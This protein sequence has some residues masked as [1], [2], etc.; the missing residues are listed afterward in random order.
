MS[1]RHG[2]DGTNAVSDTTEDRDLV[3]MI[4]EARDPADIDRIA[5][6]ARHRERSRR[7]AA[8]GSPAERPRRRGLRLGRA[9]SF[10][11]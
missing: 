2:L 7:R 5:A 3:A 10:R 6:M 9:L 4:N 11:H 8:A 1:I